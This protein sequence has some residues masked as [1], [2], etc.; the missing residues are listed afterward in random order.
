MNTLKEFSN[1]YIQAQENLNKNQKEDLLEYVESASNV[2]VKALLLSGS[3][4]NVTEE[5]IISVDK[6][7]E[8]SMNNISESI[9]INEIGIASIVDKIATAYAKHKVPGTMSNFKWP[10]WMPEIGGSQF[11]LGSGSNAAF[12]AAY[13]KAEHAAKMGLPVA[14]SVLAVMVA[15]TAKKAYTAY[16][17]KAARVCKGKSG[18]EKNNC[19]QKFY[20][21]AVKIEISNLEAGKSSCAATKNPD[22]CKL[23]INKKIKKKQNKIQKFIRKFK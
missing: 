7:F 12:N 19:F 10:S 8:L 17:S 11:T 14:A 13:D 1:Y 5:E 4:Q 6:I 18:D 2:E 3:K 22:K 20:I 16:L 21:D 9:P 23:I 15:L